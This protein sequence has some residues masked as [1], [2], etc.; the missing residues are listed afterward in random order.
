MSK[1]RDYQRAAVYKAEDLVFGKHNPPTMKC[2]GEV[3]GYM[4]RITN[5]EYWQSLKGWKRV[6]VGDGRGRNRACYKPSSKQV[7]FPIWARSEWIVIHEMAHCL[8]HKTTGGY[9]AHGT[10]FCGHY[11]SLVEEL[12]G[13]DKA[14]ELSES[15][16]SQG[17]R[18]YGWENRQAA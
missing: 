7:C 6:R 10:H 13:L 9:S 17:V 12:L 4:D 3:Q 18:W 1:V 8:T 2:L 11:L 16:K 5:S 15:F 14:I